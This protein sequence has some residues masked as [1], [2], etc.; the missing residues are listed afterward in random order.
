MHARLPLGPPPHTTH[1]HT[2]PHTTHTH[3]MPRSSST[4]ASCRFTIARPTFPLSKAPLPVLQAAQCALQIFPKT[5]PKK[6]RCDP[7]PNGT[8]SLVCAR[9]GA[10]CKCY[11]LTL[12]PPIA[13]S[14]QNKWDCISEQDTEARHYAY[15]VACACIQ[16]VDVLCGLCM[17]APIT[18]I[19]STS[20]RNKR[21][22]ACTAVSSQASAFRC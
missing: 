17:H 10:K 21:C 2:T 14:N 3:T 6:F 16:F 5:I 8:A 1:T 9:R 18:P 19:A 13:T 4:N 12:K 15:D 22:L 7:P 20:G 11:G